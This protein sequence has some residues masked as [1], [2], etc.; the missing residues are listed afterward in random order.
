MKHVSAGEAG[1]WGV[2]QDGRAYFRKGATP[3]NAKGT[4]WI[5][6][7]GRNFRQVDSGPYGVVYGVDKNGAVRCRKRITDDEPQGLYRNAFLQV[8]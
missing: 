7:S 2:G 1:V 5:K 8:Q 4:D 3:L 6:L